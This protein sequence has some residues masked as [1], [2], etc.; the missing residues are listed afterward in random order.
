[1]CKFFFHGYNH[2]VA[3]NNRSLALAPYPM[4]Q[5]STNI[6]RNNQQERAVAL[7]QPDDNQMVTIEQHQQRINREIADL[8]ARRGLSG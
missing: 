8:E 4:P 1:M 3:E 6:D 7:R 2:N 5:N